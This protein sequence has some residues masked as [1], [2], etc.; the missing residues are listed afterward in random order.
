[1][2]VGKLRA[3]DGI[4]GGSMFLVRLAWSLPMAEMKEEL[5]SIDFT[6]HMYD[7]GRRSNPA[8]FE[9]WG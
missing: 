1:M 4:G 8:A 2:K 5:P 7:V 9:A 6:H 3:V